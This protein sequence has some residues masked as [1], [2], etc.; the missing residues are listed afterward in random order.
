MDTATLVPI[1][2]QLIFLE[3]ILSIDNAAVLGAMVRHLPADVPIPIGGAPDGKRGRLKRMLGNQRDA[4]LRIG[5]FGAYAGRALMLVLAGYIISIPWLKIV[6]AAYLVYLAFNHFAELHHRGTH[7]DE[8]ED[9]A[10]R[11]AKAGFW[12]TVGA[13][14]LADLAFSL[15]NVIAAVALSNQLGIVLIGVGIGMVVMRFAAG[16]FSHMIAW[17]PAMESAAFLLL[18]AIGGELIAE[19]LLHIDVS[20]IQQFGI[21]I[22]VLLLTLLVVRTPLYGPVQMLFRPL[23]ALLAGIKG[24]IDRA[25]GVVI[26]PF[27]RA[28]AD[29]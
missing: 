21:S 2:I 27:R 20:E 16:L 9:A 13:T 15:D 1:I 8:G 26:A 6:G 19:E 14:I 11:V 22:G 25:I 5:L 3:G 10:A 18:V 17:E 7:D 28:R 24:L 23:L 12:G 29:A 4:A